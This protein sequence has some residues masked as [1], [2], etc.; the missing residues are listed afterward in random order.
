[1]SINNDNTIQKTVDLFKIYSDYTRLRIIDLLAD[2]E[3][4][5]QEISIALNTSQSAIS[6]QLKQ[7]RDNDVVTSRKEGKNIYYALKDNHIKDIF[8][9]ASNHIKNCL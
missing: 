2:E 7:L 9:I 5:V 1:M 6:H 8:L 3:F 4:C